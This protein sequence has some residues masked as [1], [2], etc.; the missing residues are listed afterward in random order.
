MKL[1]EEEPKNDDDIALTTI[2]VSESVEDSSSTNNESDEQGMSDASLDTHILKFLF[3][4]KKYERN[5]GRVCE[6]NTAYCANL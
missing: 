5:K 1:Q 4:N 3:K 6:I 2:G